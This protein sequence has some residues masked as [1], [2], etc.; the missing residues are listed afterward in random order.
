[1]IFSSIVLL[2]LKKYNKTYLNWKKNLILTMYLSLETMANK[3]DCMFL[4]DKITKIKS[5]INLLK[6]FNLLILELEK[7]NNLAMILIST[8]ETHLIFKLLQKRRKR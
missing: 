5:K 6:K 3:E 7:E 4:K 1:M 8:I 2:R